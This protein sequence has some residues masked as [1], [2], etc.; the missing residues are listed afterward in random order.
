[1]DKLLVMYAHVL[2]QLVFLL[3]AWIAV[4]IALVLR[5]RRQPLRRSQVLRFLLGVVLV[6]VLLIV[7]TTWLRR[8]FF[9]MPFV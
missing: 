7:L 5:H 3:L 1:M 6:T 9:P 8:T 2:P 4:V